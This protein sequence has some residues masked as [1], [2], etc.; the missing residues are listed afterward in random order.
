KNTC[1][2]VPAK[3]VPRSR[4]RLGKLGGELEQMRAAL[5]GIADPK[6]KA[7]LERVI[8]G[9]ERYLEDAKTLQWVFPDTCLDLAVGGSQVIR[10]GGRE[11]QIRYFG[12]AHTAGDLVVFLP[13]ERILANGDLWNSAGAGSG[14]GRDG[15]V[16]ETPRTLRAIAELD[17]D[18]VTPGHGELFHGKDALM[19]SIAGTESM[20]SRVKASY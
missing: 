9:N 6:V 4:Y 5:P 18:T 15:S 10:E 7:D 1:W 2:G 8:A 20:I 16:L 19:K 3:A 17:F 11:V 12:R 14:G 13:K